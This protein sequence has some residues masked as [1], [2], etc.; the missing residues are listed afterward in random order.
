MGGLQFE[1]TSLCGVRSLMGLKLS[2]LGER[3]SLVHPPVVHEVGV[4][5]LCYS[6]NMLARFEA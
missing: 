5:L 4:R 1:V 2:E 6:Y 3:E